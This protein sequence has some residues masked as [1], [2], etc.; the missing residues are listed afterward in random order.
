MLFIRLLGLFTL[1]LRFHTLWD[2]LTNWDLQLGLLHISMCLERPHKIGI[3][4]DKPCYHPVS[5]QFCGY[6]R[7]YFGLF[8]DQDMADYFRQQREAHFVEC[9]ESDRIRLEWQV[10][11]HSIDLPTWRR[12][13]G[14]NWYELRW[15]LVRLKQ[16]LSGKHICLIS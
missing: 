10:S 14:N 12:W 6:W 13:M 2:I 7:R 16:K 15:S 3:T 1:I 9:T 8:Y 5:G 4:V 11:A